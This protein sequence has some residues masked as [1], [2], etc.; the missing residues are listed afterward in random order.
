MISSGL[1]VD[2]GSTRRRR[3]LWTAIDVLLVVVLAMSVV[4]LHHEAT[5]PATAVNNDEVSTQIQPAG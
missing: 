3:V 2:G 4:A 5:A 1:A